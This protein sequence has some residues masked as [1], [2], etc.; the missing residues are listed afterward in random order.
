M[1]GRKLDATALD[2]L[3]LDEHEE[4]RMCEAARA[5]FQRFDVL[6]REVFALPA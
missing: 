1:V 3:E 2:R 4:A 5:A 6:L